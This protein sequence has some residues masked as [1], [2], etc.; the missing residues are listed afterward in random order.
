VKNFGDSKNFDP[1]ESRSQNPTLPRSRRPSPLQPQGPT[2]SGSPAL[3]LSWVE[4]ALTD[5]RAIASS[6]LPPLQAVYGDFIR[7]R[8]WDVFGT[9][10]F[11]DWI[12]PERANKL[13]N[14]WLRA[15]Q[16]SRF[17][18]CRHQPLIW[19]RSTEMQHRRVIHYHALVAGVTGV[20]AFAAIRLWE[21]IASGYARIVPYDAR[22]GAAYY[23]VKRGEIDLSP[24]WFDE[25]RRIEK[26]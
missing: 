15:I 9:F 16:H 12:H 26:L 1:S 20:P 8:P 10:T 2:T 13:W 23:I 21:Q 7:Y 14:A 5:A 19:V 18:T 24:D 17:R 22:R 25:S 4:L 6:S 3:R 11:Q